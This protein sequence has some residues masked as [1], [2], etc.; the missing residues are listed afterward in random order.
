MQVS[1][2][3]KSHA[4]I[5][6]S[7]SSDR[8]WCTSESPEAGLSIRRQAV[9]GMPLYLIEIPLLSE[10]GTEYEQLVRVL[11][12]ARTRIKRES[13]RSGAIAVGLAKNDRRV[14]YLVRADSADA[15]AQLVRTAMLSG[16]VIEV[17]ELEDH[18][19]S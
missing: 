8:Q 6:E 15:A 14:H 17:T 18:P 4:P 5:R 1:Q 13:G 11:A 9:C 3:V 16:Q 7:K 19:R 12:S 10:P 2:V